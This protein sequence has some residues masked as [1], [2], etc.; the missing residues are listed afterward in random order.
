MSEPYPGSACPFCGSEDTLDYT[1]GTALLLGFRTEC[2]TCRTRWNFPSGYPA[3]FGPVIWPVA[4]A[5]FRQP[6]GGD[7]P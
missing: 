3:D 1:P 4:A 2:T 5:A 6:P 7:T